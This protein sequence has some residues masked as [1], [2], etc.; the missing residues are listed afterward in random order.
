MSYSVGKNNWWD[1]HPGKTPTCL[2]EGGKIKSFSIHH[3][4]SSWGLENIFSERFL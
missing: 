2:V 1:C 3:S 4:S